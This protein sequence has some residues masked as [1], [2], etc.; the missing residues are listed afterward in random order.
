MQPRWDEEQNGLVTPT[1]PNS[2][3]V[4]TRDLSLRGQEAF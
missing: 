1:L 3:R 2:M 4:L